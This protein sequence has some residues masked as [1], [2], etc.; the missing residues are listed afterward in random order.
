M[1]PAFFHRRR[2]F[3]FTNCALFDVLPKAPP[4][5]CQVKSPVVYSI[6][7]GVSGGVGAMSVN[8]LPDIVMQADRGV[9]KT[10]R[11]KGNN[12]SLEMDRKSMEFLRFYALCCFVP[13]DE[14][15]GDRPDGGG[16][17]RCGA[18]GHRDAGD[19]LDWAGSPGV[20]R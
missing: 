5:T 15:S 1:N 3:L 7:G 18:M 19:R 20:P 14:S 2:M 11:P 6:E 17:R 4:T 10:M 8:L 12:F 13:N 9:I 16:R